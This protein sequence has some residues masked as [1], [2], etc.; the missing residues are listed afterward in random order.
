MDAEYSRSTVLAFG[1]LTCLHFGGEVCHRRTACFFCRALRCGLR[2][3]T[4]IMLCL[5]A[6]GSALAQSAPPPATAPSSTS[7]AEGDKADEKDDAK[8]DDA[9]KGDVKKDDE[10]K[11]GGSVNARLAPG[12]VVTGGSSFPL[13]IQATFDNSL[14]NAIFA[15]ASCTACTI[16]ICCSSCSAESSTQ[17]PCSTRPS[18]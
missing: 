9:K 3:S 4:T 6:A 2:R 14:G 18:K 11:E 8:K 15:P 1:L 5:L 7:A 12:G 17:A 10:K 16:G 13:H